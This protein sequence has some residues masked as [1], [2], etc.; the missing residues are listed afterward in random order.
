MKKFNK[1][2]S[3]FKCITFIEFLIIITAIALLVGIFMPA[4]GKLRNQAGW[5]ESQKSK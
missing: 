2:I 3:S 5:T 4:K 1:F